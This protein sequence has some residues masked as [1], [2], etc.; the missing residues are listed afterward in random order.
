MLYRIAWWVGQ[1]FFRFYHPH[2]DGVTVLVWH[3]GRLLVVRNSYRETWGPPGGL[4]RRRAD[5]RDEA[6]RELREEVGLDLPLDLLIDRGALEVEHSYVCDHV[7]FFEVE[8]D[9]EPA[10]QIDN[11]EVVEARFATP[12][13]L[14]G[15]ELW[16]PLRVYLARSAGVASGVEEE[17]R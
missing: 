17:S 7:R 12:A 1:R 8:F 10:L 16:V 11:R 9:T 2:V 3:A 5:A 14:E 15:L 6:A 4:R 13:E